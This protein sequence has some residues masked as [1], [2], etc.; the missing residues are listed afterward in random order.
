[1]GVTE[2]STGGQNQHSLL[3]DT[4]FRTIAAPHFSPDGQWILFAASGPPNSNLHG[5]LAPQQSCEPALLCLLAQPAYADGLPWDL[6]RIS[7]DGTRYEQLTNV[8]A[9]S[10]WPVWSRDGKYV[11]FYATSGIYLVDVNTR[12]INQISR[13]GGHG[14][15]DWWS[16]P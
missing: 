9:D 10:P 14:V 8:G 3:A 6:W 1:M 16:Q 11:A 12:V 2:Y 7:V 15:F 13:N 5:L 4:V